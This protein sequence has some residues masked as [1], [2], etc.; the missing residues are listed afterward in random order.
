MLI[1]PINE[2][3]CNNNAEILIG[4]QIFCAIQSASPKIDIPTITHCPWCGA[5]LLSKL[6]TEKSSKSWNDLPDPIADVK[7]VIEEGD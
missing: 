1:C 4:Q 7:R 3:N 2:N 6:S 5:K